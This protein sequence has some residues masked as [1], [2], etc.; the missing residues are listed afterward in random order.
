[1]LQRLRHFCFNADNL[2][3]TFYSYV[4]GA[5]I[6]DNRTVKS[7]LKVLSTKLVFFSF[8]T[9][10]VCYELGLFLGKFRFKDS[11]VSHVLLQSGELGVAYNGV[12]Y[13]S[14]TIKFD[15]VVLNFKHAEM[16]MDRSATFFLCVF[17]HLN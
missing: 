13:I 5:D 10:R 2:S 1:M 4:D 11:R 15:F 14:N 6:P 8:V 7:F 16:Q 12:T 3:F 17:S 9:F